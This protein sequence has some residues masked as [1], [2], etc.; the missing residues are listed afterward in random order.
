LEDYFQDA[1]VTAAFYCIQFGIPAESIF[2][3]TISSFGTIYKHVR[4][5]ES[6]KLIELSGCLRVSAN[7]EK[8]DYKEYVS[9]KSAWLHPVEIKMM[10]SADKKVCGINEFLKDHKRRIRG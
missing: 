5:V 8:K 7:A 9:E 1:L 10:Q 3:C 4:R 2:N 6:V